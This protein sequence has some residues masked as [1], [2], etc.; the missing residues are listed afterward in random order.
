MFANIL[1]I[2]IFVLYFQINH[3]CDFREKMMSMEFRMNFLK[4]FVKIKAGEYFAQ[5][6]EIDGFLDGFIRDEYQSIFL[7]SMSKFISA[8]I[9]KHNYLL[10][11]RMTQKLWFDVFYEHVTHCYVFWSQFCDDK[12]I[13]DSFCEVCS[14]SVLPKRCCEDG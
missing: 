7:L 13:H 8:T 12:L 14:E 2:R 10:K 6:V 11:E 3:V 9:G 4:N 1:V 5:K